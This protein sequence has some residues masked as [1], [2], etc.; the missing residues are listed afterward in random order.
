MSYT[1]TLKPG[2]VN[3]VLPDANR[4]QGG[5]VV[6][7]TDEQYFRLSATA[8]A[9]LFASVT[10][11]P[12][13]AFLTT[14]GPPDNSL[15]V[16]GDWA[17]DAGTKRLY[18]PRGVSVWTGFSQMPAPAGAGW[19]RA[20]FAALSGQDLYLTHIADG[21]GSG[22]S[23]YSTPQPTEGL[24]VTFDVEMSGGTGADGV[25]F[26]MAAPAT[27]PTFAGGGGG[28][29]GLTGA[30]ATAL[31]LDTGAGSRARIVTTDATTMTAV[32]TYGGVLTLRPNPVTIRV[33]YAAGVL[34]VWV[35]GVQIFEQA[36]A[37]SPTA[38]LGFTGSNGG[39]NDNHIIRNVN[40][41]P[42]GGVAL[43]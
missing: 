19:Q 9:A 18:G 35:A 26:A 33:Q 21:F 24:D 25:T 34:Q 22:T 23:W 7:L 1:V 12:R 11:Q 20:G 10:Q 5:D 37:V 14:I 4:H 36:V 42:R 38:L 41:V 28:E 30:V 6:S 13:S 40:F 29:L 39:S 43:L 27:S 16:Q 31:A 32:A 3:V 8:S 15:G 2:L 17:F